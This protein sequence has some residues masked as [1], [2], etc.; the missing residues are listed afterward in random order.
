MPEHCIEYISIIEWKKHFNRPV[1][2]DSVDDIKWICDEAK[3]RGEEYGIFGIDMSLTLGVIKNV[4]P[5]IASTNAII[6][7]ETVLEAI[8]LL[9]GVSK[10][11]DNYFMYMG[12]EGLFASNEKYEKNDQC[13]TCSKPVIDVVSKSTRLSDVIDSLRNKLN[14]KKVFLNRGFDTI[15]DPAKEEHNERLGLSISELIQGNILK[16]I[17]LNEN[18]KFEV[19][20]TLNNQLYNYRLILRD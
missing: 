2:T 17:K 1:D 16:D 15:Y 9:T 14:I 10:T 18:I 7:A 4:I 3:K 12:H 20:D 5:A 19:V 6:A 8:K 11:L 13:E